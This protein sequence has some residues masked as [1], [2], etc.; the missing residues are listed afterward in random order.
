MHGLAALLVEFPCGRV[1]FCG[2]SCL[3]CIIAAC[4]LFWCCVGHKK[5]VVAAAIIQQSIVGCTGT[6]GEVHTRIGGCHSLPIKQQIMAHVGLF[7]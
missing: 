2:W 6:G 7:L 1:L 5:E 3:P 4:S